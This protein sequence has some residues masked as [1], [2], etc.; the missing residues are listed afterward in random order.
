VVR[1]TCHWTYLQEAGLIC[2]FR[3]KKCN[4][5]FGHRGVTVTTRHSYVIDYKYVWECR[6]CGVKIKRHSNSF[7]PKRQRCSFC[8]S[9][10]VQIRP[11]P[12]NAPPEYQ[13]IKEVRQVHPLSPHNEKAVV[14]KGV[15]TGSDGD[16]DSITETLSRLDLRRQVSN[17]SEPVNVLR[18]ISTRL[19]TLVLHERVSLKISAWVGRASSSGPAKL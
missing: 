2:K 1:F 19:L 18:L 11:A 8:K 6:V 5:A 9:E 3:G 14:G 4:Q 12:Q 10:L 17:L 15:Q 16:L 7:D 13:Y